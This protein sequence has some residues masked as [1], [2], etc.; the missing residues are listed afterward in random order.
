VTKDELLK[1]ADSIS[2]PRLVQTHILDGVPAVLSID[3]DSYQSI[4]ASFA[5]TVGA[6]ADDITIVGS[7]KLGYSLTPETFGSPFTSQSD[8]DI[9]VVNPQIYD[10]LWWLLSSWSFP[11]RPGGWPNEKRNWARDRLERAFHG[12]IEPE[13]FFYWELG[14]RVTPPALRDVRVEWFNAL[15][16]LSQNAPLAGHDCQ[17]RIYRSWPHA[18]RY[19]EWSLNQV[20][21]QV[22]HKE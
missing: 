21:S 7:A 14:R 10:R 1:A 11:W 8:I 3:R 16:Q 20:L 22:R 4:R 18:A 13:L 19:H 6:S 17:A 12:W 2:V 9:V 5:S 15:K